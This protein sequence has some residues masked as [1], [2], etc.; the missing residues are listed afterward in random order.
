MTKPSRSRRRS[1]AA[2]VRSTRGSD[3]RQEADAGQQ[4]QAGVELG[5]AIGLHERSQLFVKTALADVFAN[6]IAQLA[7]VVERPFK[8]ERLRALDC[9]I[10]R[11]PSHDLRIGEMLRRPAHF[12]NALIGLCQIFFEMFEEF[13]LAMS[14]PES[15]VES[16]QRRAW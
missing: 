5:R 9:A 13:E 1:I 16:P 15:L 7:P 12:P 11:D 8:P 10:E 3:D 14:Q 4:Q 2:M 6:L